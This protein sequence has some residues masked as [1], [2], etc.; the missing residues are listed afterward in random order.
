MANKA[1]EQI[2]QNDIINQMIVNGWQLGTPDCYNRELA[3]YEEDVLG[4]V[5]DTQDE[6][7]K[8]YCKLYPQ[9]PE[10]HFLERVATQ[11]N[12]VDPNAANRELRTFGPLGVLRHELRDRGTRFMKGLGDI[13]KSTNPIKFFICLA[14]PAS[15]LQ[16]RCYLFSY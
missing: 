10:R 14:K 6:Q 7:W 12:K 15:E 13:D 2:F 5:Q 3:L 16:G 1:N 8:K 11:L 9:N 4:F